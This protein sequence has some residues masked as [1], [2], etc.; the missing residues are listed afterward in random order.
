M[1]EINSCRLQLIKYTSFH[2]IQIRIRSALRS[3]RKYARSTSVTFLL[4]LD[5]FFLSL[6]RSLPLSLSLF[7]DLW[8]PI[9]FLLCFPPL[10]LL[11]LSLFFL[12]ILNFLEINRN[13]TVPFEELFPLQIQG[14][15][16][17]GSVD[18]WE[19]RKSSFLF[20][21]GSEGLLYL[22]ALT[23]IIFPRVSALKREALSLRMG[24][25]HYQMSVSRSALR[26]WFTNTCGVCHPALSLPLSLPLSVSL[27]PLQVNKMKKQRAID[28]LRLTFHH[29]CLFVPQE[30]RRIRIERE[31]EKRFLASYQYRQR[32]LL[33]RWFRRA[34]K[35]RRLK[36]LDYQVCL[37]FVWFSSYFD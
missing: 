11:P 20:S 23:F 2:A 26:R 10:S 34:Q 15:G 14:N 19:R 1:K 25:K 32:I 28:L 21:I 12:S 24:K 5:F 33:V 6:C 4:P 17:L 3:L 22:L 30:Q 9:F 31:V 8:W 13:R 16:R 27:D 37:S 35:T 36:I 18:K 29:W 7:V